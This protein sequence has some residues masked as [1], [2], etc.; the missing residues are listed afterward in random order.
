MRR[1][2]VCILVL[3]GLA[4]PLSAAAD[5]IHL[6]NGQVVTGTIAISDRD[7]AVLQQATGPV[8]YR[9]EKVQIRT[10]AG[11]REFGRDDVT[12]FAITCTKPD[13]NR[14]I[15]QVRFPPQP[16]KMPFELETAHYVIKT[17]ITPLVCKKTGKAM[18]HLYAAY[19]KVF[20]L[21]DDPKRP[22]A[23]V[24]IFDKREDFLAYAKRLNARPRKDT[25]GFYRSVANGPGQIVTYKRPAG[26][27]R[28]LSTLYHEATHQFILMA[29]GH[30]NAPPL[31][32]N[33]GLAVYFENSAWRGGKLRTGIV[34][35]ARLLHL[36]QA[37]KSGKYVPLRDLITRGRDKY[38][39]L[40]YGEGW[41]LVYFFV[42]ARRG[43]YAKRLSEYFK[44]LK[45]RT[46]HAE[47]FRTCLSKDVDKLE[48]VW[49]KYV[50]GLKAPR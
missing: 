43:A 4:L 11:V 26:E 50:L 48:K 42:T 6:A 44:A 18:E 8:W 46:P 30:D 24:I 21:P 7:R 14:V 1:N 13:G 37:L 28:T 19:T 20:A 32:L 47:A 3:L 39:S 23:H 40:C 29:L 38:D 49:K 36:Q 27:F 9:R 33:E 31:W 22:K 17:D 34:P 12:H 41:S 2:M 25:L 5:T 45:E 10:A 15:V 35:R 16:L